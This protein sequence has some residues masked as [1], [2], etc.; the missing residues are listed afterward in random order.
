MDV[1][2][3]IMN[4]LFFLFLIAIY[5]KLNVIASAF[6]KALGQGD[7]KGNFTQGDTDGNGTRQERPN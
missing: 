1:F 3:I 2:L 4:V 5:Q 7:K 6:T